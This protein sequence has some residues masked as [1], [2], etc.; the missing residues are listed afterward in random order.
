MRTRNEVQE[1]VPGE[2]A[3]SCPNFGKR[4]SLISGPP[5]TKNII[6]PC[7]SVPPG[8]ALRRVHWADEAKTNQPCE[9]TNIVKHNIPATNRP[10]VKG[11]RIQTHT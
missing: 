2:V 3:S 11:G 1:R 6:T 9:R 8:D 4:A 7:E 10:V 5:Y